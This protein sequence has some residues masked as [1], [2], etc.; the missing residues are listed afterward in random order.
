ME[1]KRQGKFI[2]VSE[3]DLQK[4]QAI[5]V[6]IKGMDF[7]VRLT[8][9]IFQNKDGSSG[10]L[11][12]VT[13]DLTL[14]AEAICTTY[15]DRWGVEV[16][17]KSLKQNVALEQSPTKVDTTQSNHIFGAMIGWVKLEMLSKIKQSNHFALKKQLYVKAIKASF[18]ELQ[19]LK[20]VQLNLMAGQSTQLPLLGY[21]T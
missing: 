3:L 7:P 2:K 21:V 8:K 1:D 18:M 4:N 5:A 15:Q 13:N 9:Q 17:H 11:Y 20:Q 12:L 14:T 6:W 19:Q 10:E 16:L